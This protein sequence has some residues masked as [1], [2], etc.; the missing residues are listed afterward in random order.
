M[1]DGCM[2]LSRMEVVGKYRPCSS[3]NTDTSQISRVLQQKTKRSL[4]K[5]NSPG[6]RWDIPVDFIPYGFPRNEF[7]VN[8]DFYQ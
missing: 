4:I 3:L 1:N 8:I 5:R 2:N 7:Y 6:K